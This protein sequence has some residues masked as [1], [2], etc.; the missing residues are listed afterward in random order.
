MYMTLN[1]SACLF[2][3]VLSRASSSRWTQGVLEFCS[4]RHSCNMRQNE[5]VAAR[6]QTSLCIYLLCI[7]LSSRKLCRSKLLQSQHRSAMIRLVQKSWTEMAR[8]CSQDEDSRQQHAMVA[9]CILD[10]YDIPLYLDCL[11][12]LAALPTLP[13]L[14]HEPPPHLPHRRVTML[15]ERNRFNTSICSL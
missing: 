14:D 13:A 2:T 1:G 11:A 3:L 9:S 15:L 8:A 10:V 12:C 6:S 7:Y 5:Q 4:P